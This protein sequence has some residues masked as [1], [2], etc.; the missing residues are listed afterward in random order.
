MA[1]SIPVACAGTSGSHASEKIR[2]VVAP[3]LIPVDV[4]DASSA[5]DGN[6]DPDPGLDAGV[7]APPPANIGLSRGTDTPAD[8]ALA[9]GDAA[10]LAGQWDKAAAA[11]A[12][13]K[14]LDPKDPAPLVG[15]VR[16]TL[17]RHDVPTAHAAAPDHP[18][19]KKALVILRRALALDAKYGPAHL[20]V[21]RALL[22]MN[23]A[24]EAV[25]SLRSAVQF[26]ARDPESHSALGVA[27][28][29]I[30]K[31]QEAVEALRRSAELDPHNAA[32]QSNLGTALLL[33]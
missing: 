16:T 11:Y 26:S 10:Y 9:E 5:V 13:A 20:E 3:G 29:G 15:Q 21:G 24:N 31:G 8:Q 25:A 1:G 17:A 27:L 28:L 4:P 7:D 14:V 2:K 23:R 30:G 6:P 32:R 22:V 18:E 33:R 19:L 12:R